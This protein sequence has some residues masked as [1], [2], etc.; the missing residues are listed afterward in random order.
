MCGIVGYVGKRPAVDFLLQGLHRLEYRGYDSSGVATIS[1]E[2]RFELV[3]TAG[4]ID[5]LEEKLT[6]S[7]TAATIGIGHTRWAT[8]GAPTDENAHPHIGG[9]Q[10]VA[11]V[12]NGVIENFRP[13]RERLE[14]EGYF[15]RSASDSVVIAHLIASCLERELA[16]GEADNGSPPAP[17]DGDPPSADYDHLIRA[18]KAALAQLQGTYGLAILFREY[19]DVLFAARLGS[20]LVVGVGDGE[21]FL[22]SDG[23]PLAGNTQRIVYL[24]DHELAVLYDRFAPR[25]ASRSRAG[26]TSRAA[27]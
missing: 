4:R 7:P 22:A 12:H 16:T 10:T 18:I 27:T 1:S 24:A 9:Q 26:E 15:F 14:S 3:K 19:P 5:V 20:P 17:T 8:H 23:S 11:I 25:R 13:L 6:H 21:H 2:G